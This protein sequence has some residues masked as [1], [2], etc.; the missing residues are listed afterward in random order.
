[1]ADASSRLT[2]ALIEV[3]MMTLIGQ[4]EAEKIDLNMIKSLSDQ[5]LV[6]LGVTTIGDRLRLREKAREVWLV[7]YSLNSYTYIYGQFSYLRSYP[8]FRSPF[9]H[10]KCY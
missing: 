8:Y 6:R 2:R 5:E 3:N 1:M 9:K 7:S 4:F 10:H